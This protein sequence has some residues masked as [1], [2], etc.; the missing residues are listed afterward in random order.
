MSLNEMLPKVQTIS[1]LSQAM[2]KIGTFKT[3]KSTSLSFIVNILLSNLLLQLYIF[4]CK[5]VLSSPKN[6]CNNFNNVR[7]S[8]KQTCKEEAELANRSL[9]TA[10]IIW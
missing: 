1:A 7:L 2:L 3:H 8:G 6:D 9:K 10:I 5:A 4:S